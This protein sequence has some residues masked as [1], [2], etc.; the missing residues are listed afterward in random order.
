MAQYEAGNIPI[1]HFLKDEHDNK[2]HAEY[3]EYV[4]YVVDDSG[5]GR[6]GNKSDPHLPGNELNPDA[7][8]R[9]VLIVYQCGFEPMV[10]AV[11]S[12]LDVVIYEGDAEDMANEYL[13][14]IDW[15]KSG[16]CDYIVR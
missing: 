10:V 15:L 16:S 5:N 7:K 4:S 8:H 14:E 6:A 13:I 1:P 2:K 9:P 11:Y 3:L 12:Y